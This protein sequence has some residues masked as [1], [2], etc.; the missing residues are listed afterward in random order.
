MI[1]TLFA[2]GA[3]ALALALSVP[4]LAQDGAPAAG[5]ETPLPTMSFGEWGFDPAYIDE[6]VD[7][8]D[9][10]FAYANDKWLAANP[11]P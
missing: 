2:G 6:S 9:D 3:S 8:G 5:E 7:P 11:L 1:R 4:A 10:F